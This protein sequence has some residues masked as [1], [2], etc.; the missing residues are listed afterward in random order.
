MIDAVQEAVGEA[1]RKDLSQVLLLRIRYLESPLDQRRIQG[2]PIRLRRGRHVLRRLEPPLDLETAHPRPHQVIDHVVRGQ[3]LR[4]EEVRFVSQVA[5]RSVHDQLIRQSAGL[6]ALPAVGR[7]PA[8]R[9]AGQTLS[10]VRHAECAVD[11]DLQ[12][13][14]AFLGDHVHIVLRQLPRQDH[15]PHAKLVLHKLHAARLGQ[16][17]LRRAVHVQIGR[18]LSQEMG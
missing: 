9:L 4:A 13:H 10:G 16:R 6:R 7:A 3:I 18:E 2:R 14:V 15:P 5:L 11:E 1:A 12:R 17:H 8:Q